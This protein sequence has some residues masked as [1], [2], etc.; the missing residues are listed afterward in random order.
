MTPSASLHDATVV[1]DD[2]AVLRRAT[3]EIGPGLTLLRGPNGAGKTTLLRALAGLA[4]LA[5]GTRAASGPPLFIGQRSMLLRGLSAR[6]NLEFLAA[7][8]GDGRAGSGVGASVEQALREFGL[9]ALMDRPIERLSA[10]ERHRASL[11]RLHSEP[12]PLVFLDEPFS[13][14]DQG[15]ADLVLAAVRAAVKRGAAV[16]LV[17]HAHHELDA[18]AGARLFVVMAGTVSRG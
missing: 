10:G 1:L 8:R 15:G 3:V 11:A 5:Q 12:E 4:P 2:R 6:E 18:M 9:G 7:F 17:T 16:A 13:E 14:L